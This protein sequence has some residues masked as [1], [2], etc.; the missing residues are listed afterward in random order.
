MPKTKRRRVSREEVRANA[1]KGG[2]SGSS[3][4]TL[5]AGIREWSPD[6]AGTFRLNVLPYEVTDKNHPDGVEPGVLWYKR[7]FAVHRDVG[8]NEDRVVCPGSV[9]LPCP[10]CQEAKR[11]AKEDYEAN[12]EAIRAL[13]PQRF[14]AYNIVDPDDEDKVA[15]FAYS[16]GKFAKVLGKELE[17][18]DDEV[19]NF[20][21]VT[22]DGKTLKVRFSEAEF[23]GQKYLEA[24]RIDFLD[25]DAMD[26]DEVLGKV[27]NLDAIILPVMPYEKLKTLF[28]QTAEEP[29]EEE[30][31]APPKKKPVK[32]ADDEDEGDEPPAPK[33]K[34][35]KEEEPEEPEEEPEEE[36]DPPPKKKPAAKKEEE[37][38]EEEEP[39]EEEPEEEEEDD[40]PPK[41]TPPPA[42]TKP[43]AKKEETPEK[44]KSSK[45]VCPHKGGK[46][47]KDVDRYD[48]CDE[49]S[50]WDACEKASE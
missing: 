14:V 42:S 41:K 39:E 5:P 10:I 8:P 13:N 49:C 31:E 26:E 46:F 19:L 15:V 25:R 38:P 7:P 27:A 17:E 36:D 30:E 23:S 44:E 35:A 20:Y 1:A 24:T 29:E 3:Y 34:P 45:H 50:F 6:K 12:K 22:K 11:L 21:D 32:A 48:E 43:T 28:S 37:E 2:S 47:G 33:K 9:G 4:L 16:F 40:P 18:G